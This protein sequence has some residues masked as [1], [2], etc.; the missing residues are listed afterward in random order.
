MTELIAGGSW[1]AVARGCRAIDDGRHDF[2]DEF[3]DLATSSAN[4]RR[5]VGVGDA[6]VR[7]LREVNQRNPVAPLTA[8]RAAVSADGA[9][10]KCL[11]ARTQAKAHGLAPP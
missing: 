3:R 8:G 11:Q 5:V 6:V 7:V 10:F 9:A 1:G 2:D 4:R